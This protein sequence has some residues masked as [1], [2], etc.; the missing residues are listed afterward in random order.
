MKNT[1]DEWVYWA[2]KKQRWAER[3]VVYFVQGKREKQHKA[4]QLLSQKGN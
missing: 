2:N 3:L 1:V 4:E